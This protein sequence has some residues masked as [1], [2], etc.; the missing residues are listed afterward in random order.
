MT[1]AELRSLVKNLLRKIDKTNKYHNNVV[2]HTISRVVTQVFNEVFVKNP[3]D[4]NNYT[5]DVTLT[6]SEY[7]TDTGRYYSDSIANYRYIPL[8][9][10]ASGVRNIFIPPDLVS[11][12]GDIKFY[13]MTRTEFDLM[14]HTGADTA[15]ERGVASVR[16]GYVVHT[17]K[18]DFWGM[19]DALAAE[20][21]T[22]QVLQ[23]F[24]VYADTDEVKLPYGMDEVVVRRSAEIL[25]VIP[26]VDLKDNNKEAR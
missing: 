2:D 26:P 10:K 21:I 19:P 23:Q 25:S 15:I 4:L 7:G 17:D 24:T 12:Y 22:A 16:V 13:P 9:D 6:I 11:S 5:V 1:K 8:P 3:A 14:N 18:I 20:E